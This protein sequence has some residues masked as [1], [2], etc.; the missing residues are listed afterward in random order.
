MKKKRLLDVL[1]SLYPDYERERL[2]AN[3]LCGDV[4]VDGVRIKD[5]FYGVKSSSIVELK[6]EDGYVSRGGYK[7]EAA[8][9]EWKL[10]VRGLCFVDVG[11][12]TGGFTDCLLSRGA[13]FVHAVDVGY[14][15]LAWKLRADNRVSVMERCNIRDIKELVPRPDAAVA[16]VSFSSLTGLIPHIIGLTAQKWGVFL[17]KP[18]FEYAAMIKHG[19]AEDYG[20]DG[21]IRDYSIVYII[22]D[23][24]LERIVSEGLCVG[25]LM[26]SPIRGSHGNLEFLLLISK[27]GPGA[28]RDELD[29]WYSSVSS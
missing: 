8:L 7:L 4:F 24:I 21:V 16:D 19:L 28:G 23:Y 27:G 6:S 5:P 9:S 18:Q 29:K 10:D 17:L 11:S 14:N 12:S 26:P 22:A 25:H 20:F 3:I 2:Y 15:Q 13:S 1:V